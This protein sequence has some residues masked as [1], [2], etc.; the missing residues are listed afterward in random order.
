MTCNIKKNK[1]SKEELY[2]NER[3]EFF[4]ELNNFLGLTDDCHTLIFNKINNDNELKQFIIDNE[5]KIKKYFKY[6]KWGY[7]R[8]TSK[9]KEIAYLIKNIYKNFNYIIHTKLINLKD[10]DNII[11]ATQIIFYKPGRI[12]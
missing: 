8:K 12:I 7:F 10:N 11:K 2:K 6:G 1:I 4:N 9:Q 5:I 3:L